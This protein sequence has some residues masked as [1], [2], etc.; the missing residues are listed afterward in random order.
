MPWNK[1]NPK[2]VGRK[3]N[4]FLLGLVDQLKDPYSWRA[5][6]NLKELE[7]K[8]TQTKIVVKGNKSV[9]PSSSLLSAELDN[10]SNQAEKK[11]KE[12][13]V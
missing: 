1:N 2:E 3:G 9:K 12:L 7:L 13:C 11:E 4:I 10:T 5:V 8:F 6:K